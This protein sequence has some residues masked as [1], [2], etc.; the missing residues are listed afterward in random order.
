MNDNTEENDDE[1]EK[2]VTIDTENSER[3]HRAR[4]PTTRTGV[5]GQPRK[6]K[7]S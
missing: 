6:Q 1:R 4:Q 7:E 2:E 3:E 5:D